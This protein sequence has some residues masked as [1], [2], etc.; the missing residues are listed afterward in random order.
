MSCD[1]A[2]NQ[3]YGSLEGPAAS[4]F[5]AI[6]LSPF[7]T[8]VA[9]CLDTAGPSFPVQHIL[10]SNSTTTTRCRPDPVHPLLFSGP[11]KSARGRVSAPLTAFFPPRWL[12]M[13][14]ARQCMVH[15]MENCRRLDLSATMLLAWKYSKLPDNLGHTIAA[16]HALAL[17]VAFLAVH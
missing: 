3:N 10:H 15:H 12:E 11:L 7:F 17:S 2:A 4:I 1:E 5:C 14:P 13:N 8:W 16:L 6:T 9:A